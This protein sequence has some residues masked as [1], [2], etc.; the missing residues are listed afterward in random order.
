MAASIVDKGDSIEAGA[1]VEL[2]QTRIFMGGTDQPNRGQY[3]VARDGRFL[4]NTVID[5]TTPPIIVV[6]NWSGA[7]Q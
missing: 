2:F 1:P 4:I 6:Q 5:D 7:R 3:D